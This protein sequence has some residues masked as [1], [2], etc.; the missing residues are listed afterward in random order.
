MRLRSTK[1]T[2]K[3]K[4]QRSKKVS[5]KLKKQRSKKVTKKLKKQ[6]SKKVTKKLKKQRSKKRM[7]MKSSFGNYSDYDSDYGSDNE[8]LT[9]LNIALKAE[10][11]D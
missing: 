2:K 11:P 10:E 4:K 5:K 7:R 1:V 6:R 9:P 8:G 3:L